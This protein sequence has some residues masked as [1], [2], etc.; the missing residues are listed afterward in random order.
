[1]L[2]D[3]TWIAWVESN[4]HSEYLCSVHVVIM[5]SALSMMADIVIETRVVN[6]HTAV[7]VLKDSLN[8]LGVVF[9]C[10]ENRLNE[11]CGMPDFLFLITCFVS[12]HNFRFLLHSYSVSHIFCTCRSAIRYRT[13][14]EYLMKS[15][16]QWSIK[17]RCCYHGG[18]IETEGASSDLLGNPCFAQLWSTQSVHLSW[19]L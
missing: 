14:I 5:C 17:R 13:H 15:K 9:D 19:H 2:C 18:Y 3:F 4:T 10:V 7:T 1:M 11:P 16:G 6:K 12:L 8:L